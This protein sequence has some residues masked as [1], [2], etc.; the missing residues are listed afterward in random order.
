MR[1]AHC[2]TSRCSS[3]LLVLS[4]FDYSSHASVLE[5]CAVVVVMTTN[6]Y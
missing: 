2:A 3:E 5:S 1:D 4:A 6:D